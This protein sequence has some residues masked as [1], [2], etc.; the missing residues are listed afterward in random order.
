MVVS[1]FWRYDV[2]NAAAPVIERRST[3]LWQ[4]PLF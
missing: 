2:K 3:A 1:C 4:V